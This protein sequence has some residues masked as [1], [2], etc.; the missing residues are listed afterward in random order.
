MAVK[1][2]IHQIFILAKVIMALLG[3][4]AITFTG[5]C[6]ISVI[7]R[8]SGGLGIVFSVFGLLWTF[9][10]LA[11][12]FTFPPKVAVDNE[13]NLVS[14]KFFQTVILS[15]ESISE[16][17][18]QHP[19]MWMTWEKLYIRTKDGRWLT[20]SKFF[21]QNYDEL[22]AELFAGLPGSVALTDSRDD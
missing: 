2:N 7:W 21:Y 1:S 17:M 16:V 14:A 9:I 15:Y 10:C 13:K 19:L 22:K 20:I 8:D 5:L 12:P 11:F 18:I 4:P 6:I 3:I